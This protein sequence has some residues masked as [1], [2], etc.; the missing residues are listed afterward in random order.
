MRR[1]CLLAL[2]AHLCQA[3]ADSVDGPGLLARGINQTS[4]FPGQVNTITLS[5]G[6]SVPQESLTKVTISGL[7]TT[8]TPSGVLPLTD[9]N[10]SKYSVFNLSAPWVQGTGTLIVTVLAEMDAGEV[11]HLSFDLV[12]PLLPQHAPSVSISTQGTLAY[13]NFLPVPMLQGPLN[14]AALVII[15]WDLRKI[16]QATPAT[17]AQNTITVTFSTYGHL[18][19]NTARSTNVSISGLKGANQSS[20]SI[21]IMSEDDVFPEYAAWNHT[22]AT[23][24]FRIIKTTRASYAYVMSFVLQNP[25]VGQD[26]PEPI[27]LSSAWPIA[28]APMSRATGFLTPL[29]IHGFVTK[30]LQQCDPSAGRNNTLILKL[31]SRSPVPVS[32]SQI[33]IQ[34]A[35]YGYVA[36]DLVVD[37]SSSGAGSGFRA[38]FTVSEYEPFQISCQTC[39]SIISTRILQLG[40]GYSEDAL[41]TPVYHGTTHPMD[42]SISIALVV[43]QGQDYVVADVRATHQFSGSGFLGRTAV[44]HAGRVI[45]LQIIDHGKDYGDP[46]YLRFVLF[47]PNTNVEMEN[48]I[49][50]LNTFGLNLTSGCRQDDVITGVGGGGQDFRARI[51]QV[52]YLSGR[53]IAYSIIYHG[54]GYSSPPQL[55]VS[56]AD[57]KCNETSGSLAGNFDVCITARRAHGVSIGGR[58]A[59]DAVV[60]GARPRVHLQLPGVQNADSDAIA[61]TR[62]GFGFDDATAIFGTHAQW[63]RSTATLLL[64][65]SG[66]LGAPCASHHRRRCPM[67]RRQSTCRT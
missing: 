37:T 22:A 8:Q 39:G 11:Y 56:N 26:A 24:V 57:C 4:E 12:N 9:L 31:S 27:E 35:G 45:D 42:K 32:P 5:I 49:S 38:Y 47:Y 17:A 44:D 43:S 55:I 67:A 18:I 62:H 66:N 33:S 19:W 52:D 15:G 16:A 51:D 60:F 65:F 50:G 63:T 54:T 14:S 20:A 58:V 48:S 29:L 13:S 59:H 28:S 61:L 1:I 23:L 2:S 3:V 21:K 7:V 34:T 10:S 40:E 6:S 53:I 64:R 25:D 41:L 30:F 46:G 36:G